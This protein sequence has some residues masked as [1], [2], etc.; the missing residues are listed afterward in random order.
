MGENDS[1]QAAPGGAQ[2][3]PRIALESSEQIRELALA[4]VRSARRSIAIS[5]RQLGPRLYDNSEFA[6]AVKR[7]ALSSR[8]ARVRLLA[9]EARELV[10]RGHRLIDLAQQ[11]S[12]FISIR[13]PSQQHAG[14]N[15]AMLVVDE[16]LYPRVEALLGIAPD[17]TAGEL[18][19]ENE[20]PDFSG[21]A[22]LVAE[23]NVVNRQVVRQ[24]LDNLEIAADYV[25]DGQAAVAAAVA[26][27]Y[28][29][30]L[31][32]VQMP[33]MDGMAAAREI[34]RRCGESAG[35]AT[36]G[37]QRH[38][39][40]MKRRSLPGILLD[41]MLKKPVVTRTASKCR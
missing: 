31:M 38:V 39:F 27:A 30:V 12:S 25:D 35:W 32:D 2:A 4:M 24:M 11:L 16:R 36:V 8:H 18:R 23:D 3:D 17:E 15:E 13:V 34:R 22:V 6:E 26:R 19:S 9:L 29:L 5:G 33:V 37:W 20:R 21:M 28:D 40:L 1:E 7:L 14:F 41:G 10:S